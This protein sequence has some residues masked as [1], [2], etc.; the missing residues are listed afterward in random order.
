MSGFTAKRIV[1][2]QTHL[3]YDEEAIKNVWM[4]QRG[5]V[6]ETWSKGSKEVKVIHKFFF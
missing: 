3:V 2:K 6:I 4:Y 1:G 5:M